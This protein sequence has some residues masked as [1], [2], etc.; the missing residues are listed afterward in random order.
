[1]KEFTL[2]C[3][4]PLP[5]EDRVLLAHGGG[6]KLTQQL[7]ERVFLPQFRNA[8]LEARHDGAVLTVAGARLAFTTDSYVVRPLIFPGGNIGD[9]AVNGTVND[10]AMCGARPLYLSAGFI[11]EEGLA[12][13]TLERIVAS[14][15]EAARRGRRGAGHRRHQGGGQGQGRR[16]VHQH[17]GHRRGGGGRGRFGRGAW[18]R[19]MRS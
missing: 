11:L 7:I 5:A 9:L 19:G 16:R 14:M 8:A 18:S 17:G 13:E 6:G 10:L 12:M 1:M 3:P 2:S 15:R 4:I